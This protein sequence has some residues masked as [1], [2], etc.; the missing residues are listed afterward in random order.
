MPIRDRLSRI[1][2]KSDSSSGSSSSAGSNS[3]SDDYSERRYNV[4]STI[5]TTSSLPATPRSLVRSY[6]TASS[7]LSKRTTAWL[8]TSS[9]A[10][11]SSSA[12]IHDDSHAFQPGSKRPDS[13][14]ST[15]HTVKSYHPSERRLNERNLRHQEMLGS[16]TMKFGR[17]RLS[18]GARSDISEVSP[19][20]SRAASLDIPRDSYQVLED[21]EGSYGQQGRISSSVDGS[22][23]GEKTA[24]FDSW[25]AGVLKM[26]NYEE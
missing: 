11:N 23:D 9:T 20:N 15:K 19:G 26:L 17:R 7:R 10:I 21:R 24:D 13:K 1:I 18:Q 2:R 14:R 12:A 22:L 16:F 6:T 3:S 25:A 4:L 8:S 5:G